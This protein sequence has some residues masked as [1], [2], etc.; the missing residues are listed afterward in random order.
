LL[1]HSLS[2][3]LLLGATVLLCLLLKP[4]VRWLVL[5]AASLLFYAAW[6]IE[7]LGLMF[8]TICTCH[9]G[10]LWIEQSRQQQRPNRSG[11][12][13]FGVIAINLSILFLFKYF[14]LF[15][16]SWNR[17]TGAAWIDDLGFLLPVGISFYTFQAIGYLIDVYRGDLP[18]E[19]TLARTTLFVAFFPQL[20]AGPIERAGHL[21]PAL[22][23]TIVFRW[24]NVRRGLWLI[25]WGLFKKLVIA[26]R[27]ALLVDDVYDDPSS[28]SGGL[29]LMATYA[30]AFQIYCDFSGYSDIAIG[31][32]RL[33]GIELMQNFR[34]PYLASSLRDFWSRWHISLSTWFRDYVYIPLGGNRVSRLYWF[35]N[36]VIVFILS[37]FWHGA[38]W[39]YAFWGL[40]HG[41]AIVLEIVFSR[42]ARG[43]FALGGIAD[44]K[45]P[46]GLG[47]WFFAGM[48]IVATFHIVLVAWIF[49]RA[50]SM[51]DAV[52]VLQNIVS[53]SLF[54]TIQ[55]P[56]AYSRFELAVSL[57]GIFWM[58]FVEV[59]TNGLVEN[60]LGARPRFRARA[61]VLTTL[62]LLLNFGIFTAAAQFVYFQ[63]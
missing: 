44:A 53:K 35:R 27:L 54:T 8:I 62:L 29:L 21:L 52:V 19:K 15:V 11:I 36:I 32:A 26:D 56:P 16:Q 22:R 58:F 9:W 7:Y 37:G 12:L 28:A 30:F 50:S 33:F 45:H 31:S 51:E 55:W 47:H 6:R 5:L 20:V 23:R 61:V 57:L 1:F 41:A 39:T 2:Y 59:R 10:A 3:A 14:G 25:L 49:F 13:L 4:S 46:I 42:I 17:F 40:I 60:W 43:G 38:A 24:K 18:A 63:F 48:R 34:L